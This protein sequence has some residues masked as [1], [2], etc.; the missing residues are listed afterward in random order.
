VEA[1]NHPTDPDADEVNLNSL[2]FFPLS[3]KKRQKKKN[4]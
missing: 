1:A 3:N 4:L 2:F